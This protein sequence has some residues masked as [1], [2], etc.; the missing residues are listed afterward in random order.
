MRVVSLMCLILVVLIAPIQA[1]AQAS[2]ASAASI[3][4]YHRF[5]ESALPSTNIRIEQ[6]EAH[7]ALLTSGPYTVLPLDEV[8]VA[9]QYGT[10]L[11]PNTVVITIDD[12][13]RSFVTEGWPRFKAAGLP[14][15]WFLN[16]AAVGTGAPGAPSWDDVR[17]LRDEGV[18]FGGHSHAHPHLPALS[19]AEQEA[20]IDRSLDLFEQE[21]GLRPKTFAYPYGEADRTAM[22]LMAAKG[23]VAAFGQHSGV[24][25]GGDNRW[26]LP[27]FALNEQYGAADRFRRV[28]DALPLPATDVVPSTPTLRGNPPLFGFTVTQPD[29]PLA[30]IA[31]YGPSGKL[32]TQILGPR[33]EVRMDAALPPGRARINCTLPGPRAAD[34][35]L[36][37]HW[38]GTQ[39]VVLP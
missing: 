31:C 4:M 11:P 26:Y 35:T 36:R 37:W 7:I 16:T 9:L 24:A 22:D 21:L 19:A 32:A 12:A 33:V 1:M 23:F 2:M 34:G 38:R 29:L 18:T 28:I 15:T 17:R 5:G 30:D 25:W 10:P 3:L 14:V 6:L 20:D 27:R 39:F 13:Y 8:V